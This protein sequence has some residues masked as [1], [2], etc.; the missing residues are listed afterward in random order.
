M[1]NSNLL[2]ELQQ[3]KQRIAY[4]DA[5][6]N[7]NMYALYALKERRLWWLGVS[8]KRRQLFYCCYQSQN[9]L[10]VHN[11]CQG[12]F[13]GILGGVLTGVTGVI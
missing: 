9:L 13:N 12:C 3:L 10:Q 7:K 6:I 8:I 1:Q 4:T 5:S 11:H 2:N